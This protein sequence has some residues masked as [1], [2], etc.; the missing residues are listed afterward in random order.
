MPRNLQSWNLFSPSPSPVNVVTPA[1]PL[2]FSSPFLSPPPPYF[3]NVKLTKP[4]DKVRYWFLFGNYPFRLSV[5]DYP[6]KLL[7]SFHEIV[8]IISTMTTS[9]YTH[10]QFII[11]NHTLVTPWRTVPFHKHIV[12]Q[13]VKKFT[14]AFMEAEC[15]F[16]CLKQFASVLYHELDRN[17]S[18]T[19]EACPVSPYVNTKDLQ[20]Q[21]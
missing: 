1:T 10:N 20:L 18:V 11:H 7:R 13:L 19:Y 8:C 17:H 16:T 21:N 6:A 5:I 3:R 9:T 15:E 2:T 14:P 4:L 12:A